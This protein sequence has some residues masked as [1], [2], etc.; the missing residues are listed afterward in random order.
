MLR[1]LH[2]TNAFPYEGIPEYGV[3]VKEQIDSLNNAQAGVAADVLFVNGRQGGKKAYLDGV[4]ELRGRAK[5]YDVIHC[6]HLFSGFVAALALTGKPSVLSFQNDWLHEMDNVPW[7]IARKLGCNFGAWWANRVIFKSPIPPQF[8]GNPRFIYLPNGVNGT[9][10]T[11]TSK[12]GARHALGLDP[13]KY[14]CLFV[15]SKS[16]DRPQKR[17]DRFVAVLDE[18]RRTNPDLD[19]EELVLVNQPRERVLDFF[20]A[21]DLHLMTSDYEGSPNSVKEALC[22]GL[23]IVSTDI[24]NVRDMLTGVPGCA[25]AS[26][27]EPAELA[28]L[29]AK[30]LRAPAA[31]E[32]IRDGFLAK[33]FSQ[34][35]AVRKLVALYRDVAGV[36]A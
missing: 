12:A 1:V 6:H 14:Y 33:D 31:R 24:G 2:V 9:Q 36:T 18:V 5:A 13:A 25:V 10:F 4:K 34:A 20:N 35:A 15:S 3:F 29:V 28:A 26:S 11:I 8:V 7:P 16:R 17:Y 19:V 27:F 32:A 21:A 30:V 23:A 22:C